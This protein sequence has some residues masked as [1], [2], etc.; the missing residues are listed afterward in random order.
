V[1]SSIRHFGGRKFAGG[2]QG[3]TPETDSKYA[4]CLE[5]NSVIING[6]LLLFDV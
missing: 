3:A 4:A 6:I 5:V 2:H 1:F